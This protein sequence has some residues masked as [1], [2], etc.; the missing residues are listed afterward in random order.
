MNIEFFV[1]KDWSYGAK[2][3]LGKEVVFAV[4]KT[5]KQLEINMYKGI[6]AALDTKAKKKVYSPFL[7]FISDKF[8]HAAHA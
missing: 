4:W 3:S 6:D 1:E 2:I 7:S 8:S 5:M